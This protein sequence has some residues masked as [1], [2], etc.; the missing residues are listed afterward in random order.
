[1]DVFL[2]A[3]AK[4]TLCIIA[5]AVCAA[6]PAAPSYNQVRSLLLNWEK[7]HSKG[8]ITYVAGGT[9]DTFGTNPGLSDPDRSPRW[10]RFEFDG[11]RERLITRPWSQGE[12]PSK[13]FSKFMVQ[14]TDG[15]RCFSGETIDHVRIVD[16]KSL[17]NLTQVDAPPDSI[18]PQN[19]LIRGE[20]QQKHSTW[21]TAAS[22]QSGF[23]LAR[24][25]GRIIV[26]GRAEGGVKTLEIDA[27]S[28]KPLRLLFVSDE[29][30]SVTVEYRFS[31][32]ETDG[33]RVEFSAW[34]TA[35]PAELLNRARM[36]IISLEYGKVD[37]AALEFERAPAGSS[38]WSIDGR[39]QWIVQPDG[40]RQ[41]TK[42][43][44]PRGGVRVQS[45]LPDPW[46]IAGAFAV[47]AFGG[48]VA[49]FRRRAS[50]KP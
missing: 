13:L 23:A 15:R 19:L 45:L 40:R 41:L 6:S 35:K 31:S 25:Q 29:P 43:P 18:G 36:T 1:M 9:R 24:E 49:L 38:Y 20:S 39:S 44:E 14:G 28:G 32:S 12:N 26:Q 21:M 22:R 2:R 37:S 5:G 47:A 42:S 27:Q 7:A 34:K 8:T 50:H 16:S 11:Q 10:S 33:S 48:A 30:D 17:L 46:I 3:L 4:S